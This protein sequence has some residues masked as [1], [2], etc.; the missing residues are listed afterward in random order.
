[1][2][3]LIAAIFGR[4]ALGQLSSDDYKDW[5]GEMLLQSYDSR[6]LRILAGLDRFV[7]TIEAEDYFLRAINE[8]NLRP[9]DRDAA[10]RAYAC[11]IAQRVVD[12]IILA[13][14]GVRWLFQIC[15]A[16]DY[17]RDFVI[18][19][20]LEDALDSLRHGQYPFTYESATLDNFDEIAKREA[21]NFVASLFPRSAT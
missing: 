15:I 8:L 14:D 18:W 4:R 16:T 17:A 20:E 1:M 12:D 9:P 3:Y 13:Q 21:A 11:E 7:N 2:D 5:A 10:I 19:F 6:S